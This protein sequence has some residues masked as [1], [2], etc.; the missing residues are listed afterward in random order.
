MLHPVSQ[1]LR[2]SPC[3][4]QDDLASWLRICFERNTWSF[5][6]SLMKLFSSFHAYR[7]LNE[8][9]RQCATRVQ[10]NQTL[11]DK[12]ALF[13]ERA[14]S[15]TTILYFE[16]ISKYFDCDKSQKGSP[17]ILVYHPSDPPR[18]RIQH[19]CLFKCWIV[20]VSDRYALLISIHFRARRGKHT[21]WNSSVLVHF[22]AI[23]DRQ[24]HFQ[25]ELFLK[26]LEWLGGTGVFVVH[27]V[28]NNIETFSF[29][30]HLLPEHLSFSSLTNSGPSLNLVLLRLANIFNP[31]SL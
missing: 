9:C 29:D 2:T 22:L 28:S 27:L 11:F 19:V 24:E 13:V 12:E 21:W 18:W 20:Q 1:N 10:L 16:D 7:F 31:L 30:H 5:A 6:L 4:S 25:N 17:L 14:S 15:C 23:Q 3:V 26:D 8:L